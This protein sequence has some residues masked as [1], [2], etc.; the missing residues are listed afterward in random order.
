M[1]TSVSLRLAEPFQAFFVIHCQPI[2]LY[3]NDPPDKLSAF[4]VLHFSALSGSFLPTLANEGQTAR[5]L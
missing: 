2:V 3:G 4:S 5:Q 1:Y